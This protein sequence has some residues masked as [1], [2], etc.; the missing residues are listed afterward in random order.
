MPEPT[1]PDEGA[2]LTAASGAASVDQAA[3]LRARKALIPLVGNAPPRCPR[4]GTRLAADAAKQCPHCGVDPASAEAAAMLVPAGGVVGELLRGASYVPRGLWKIVSTPRLWAVS[5]LPMLLSIAFTIG[6]FLLL[7]QSLLDWFESHTGAEPY[8]DWHGIWAFGAIVFRFLCNL[9]YYLSFV[10]IPLVL[11]WILT[12][13]P[14]RAIFAATSTLVGGRTE[15]LVLE[16]PTRK[17]EPFNLGAFQASLAIAVVDALLLALLEGVLYVVLSP[18]AV[19]P[20][21]G[22]LLWFL[23]PR[24]IFAAFD[25]SDPSFCRKNYYMREK[26]ALWRERPWRFFG[27][28]CAFFFLL[29]IPFVN[30][31]VFPVV[32]AGGALLYLELDRK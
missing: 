14:F 28:G 25:Q 19:V 4:C 5:A 22:T 7:K 16:T 9:V 3:V 26:I 6:T 31:L 1:K 17:A 13:P 10:M 8:K 27:F 21:V 18:I 24:A 23:L 30:A 20:V 12:T 2:T 32:A 15:Q 29:T 11:A